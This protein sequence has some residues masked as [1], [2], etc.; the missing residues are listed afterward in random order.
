[1]VSTALQERV[2]MDTNLSYDGVIFNKDLVIIELKQEKLNRLSPIF[3]ALK[4][5][6]I[7]P[8][9]ISKYCMGM[10]N[11]NKDLKQNLFKPKFLK[12][13]NLTA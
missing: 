8:Y 2:T 10:A 3:Q 1:M 6:S 12:I 9:S 5:Q 11:T 13:N 4:A 7:N